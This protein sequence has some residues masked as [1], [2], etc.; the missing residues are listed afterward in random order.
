[1][2]AGF[3]SYEGRGVRMGDSP[4]RYETI[5]RDVFNTNA[6]EN[7]ARDALTAI[8]TVQRQQGV[9]PE[10]IYLMGASEGTYLAAETAS[11]ASGQV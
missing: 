7:K 8:Q 6:L 5:N 10:R 9:D 1:M 3:F 2:N 4:P 11:R